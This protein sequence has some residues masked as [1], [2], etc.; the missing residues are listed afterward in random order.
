MEVVEDSS[1]S[2][3]GYQVVRGEFFAH[4]SEPS[5][6]FCNHK[7]SVNTACIKKL[8]DV[9]FVQIL[10]NPE[11]KM[12]AV[13]PCREDEKDSIRWITASNKPKQI[14]CRMFFAKVFSLMEW[15]PNYRYKLLGKLIKSDS[16]LLFVF[17]MTTPEIYQ[18]SIKDDGKI[19][20]SRTATYPEDWK[21]QFGVPAKEHQKKLQ[22]DIFNGY[23]VFSLGTNDTVPST[24][25]T[26]TSISSE[27]IRHEQTIPQDQ[28]DN[29]S[30]ADH[31][32]ETEPYS[33]SPQNPTAPR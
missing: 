33:D 18:T 27:E 32:S 16:D 31:R 15:N 6:S 1:F 29:S 14:T 8:P 11:R 26:Q 21:N 9:E 24:T 23:A 19:R 7:V 12:L 5:I 3:D 13:R 20:T 22:V 4:I 2:L 28:P 30:N 17:D 25:E 10:V